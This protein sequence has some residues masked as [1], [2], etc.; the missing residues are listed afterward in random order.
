[1]SLFQKLSR[2]FFWGFEGTA[3]S[4]EIKNLFKLC[5]PAGV[6]LFKRNIESLDQV[7]RFNWSLKELG[8]KLASH[9]I[10]ISVDQEGGR[11]GRLPPPFPQYPPAETWGEFFDEGKNKGLVFEAGYFLGSELRKAG[12][13]TDFAP[14]LDVNS[15]PQN[16]IIGD[17]AF[18]RDPKIAAE[19]AIAFYQGMK[20]AGIVAC[21]KHF[22]GHGDTN[23]DS[24]LAL[25]RVKRSWESLKKIELVPFREAIK[26]RMPMLMTAHVV[27]SALDPKK[28]ATLSKKILTG[29]LRKEMGFQGVLISDD[30][31]MKAVS[32]KYTVEESALLSLEAGVDLILIC[33]GGEM[34]PEI[35][36]KVFREVQKSSALRK[37]VDESY[38]RVSRLISLLA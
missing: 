24:H 2:L 10:F 4:P 23:Q 38:Q 29:L 37:R 34:G 6:V 16:P 18:S 30:L 9:K 32:E 13:N 21:G 27:Y 12:F 3:L 19:A 22:P 36:Q 33:R 7:K 8:K 35:V 28:P 25:P 31:K 15:N 20:K 1:M 26:F 17:R 5:P 14:I 11:V